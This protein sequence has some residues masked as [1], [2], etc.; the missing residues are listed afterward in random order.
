MNDALARIRVKETH[1]I[2]RFLYPLSATVSL[3]DQADIGKIGLADAH[4]EAI[5]L[6]LV[7]D[8]TAANT[9]RLDFAVFLDPL[10]ETDLTLSY[11]GLH[12]TFDDPLQV[13]RT[14]NHGWQSVQKRFRL[15]TDADGAIERVAYDGAEHLRGRLSI[16]RNGA[17]MRTDALTALHTGLRFMLTGAGHYKDNCAGRTTL[18][19][20]ACKSWA[21]VTHRLENAGAYESVD[22]TLPFA[23][24]SPT[25]T[26]DVGV[27]NGLYGKLHP[28]E[29]QE[30]VWH[31]VFGSRPYA[32]WSVT[33]DERRDYVGV[34]TAEEF[35]AQR[36]FHLIDSDKALAVAITE[37]PASC[38]HMAVVLK[39][40]GN[41]RVSYELEGNQ[42]PVAEFGVCYHFLNAIPAIAAA[43]NPLSILLPPTVDVQPL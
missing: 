13:S 10:S 36:W 6:R 23:V 4:G 3:P 42:S 14:V 17:E 26:Y 5:P 40:D 15:E 30:V 8:D 39:A 20:T 38:K 21:T 12:T 43:T 24:T 2:R 31:T 33:V 16:T 18:D 35:A 11:G 29:P 1:G 27:G 19:L 28:E 32:R 41:V 37:V 22:F 9:Y 7:A 34:A 25:L